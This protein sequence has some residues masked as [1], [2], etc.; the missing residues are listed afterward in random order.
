MSSWTLSWRLLFRQGRSG[1]L[2]LLLAGLVVA[3]AALTAVGLF[4]DRVSRALERQASETLAADL[5]IASR[6]PSAET[7][8][9]QAQ[10][11]G[12]ESV[13]MVTI[14][15]AVFINDQ[16]QL[17]DI[18]A[19]SEGY[20]LRG[21]VGVRQTLM[22]EETRGQM[23]PTRG[24]AWFEPRG[25]RELG[26]EIDDAMDIGQLSL[27]LT[28]ALSYEPDGGGSQFM[29]APRLLMHIDDLKDSGLLG[30]GA[31]TRYRLLIAGEE[32][33]VAAYARWIQNQWAQAETKG[34]QRLITP[35]EGEAQTAEALTQARRFLG[36]AALTTVI[37]AA[38][39]ILL[40]ALRFALAQ[41]DLVALLK[42]FGARST[43]ILGALTWM[44]AWLVA[45]AVVMGGLA[46]FAVQH[47]L[48]EVLSGVGTEGLPGPRLSPW[49]VASSL[50]ALLG[51]G[52]ALPPLWGLKRVAPIRILNRSLDQQ[53]PLSW[54]LWLVL[55]AV[56]LAIPALQLGDTTLAVIVLGGALG[57]AVVLAFFAWLAMHLTRLASRQAKAAWRFGLAGLYRRR[58][59]GIIQITALGLGLMALLLLMVVRSEL[60]T[61]WQAT[62]PEDAPNH[63]VV[64]IQ[65]DQK[66]AVFD[67]LDQAGAQNLQMGPMA[68]VRLI[69][70]NDEPPP[71][72]RFTG[73]VNVSWVSP[74][75]IDRLPPAN[76]ISAGRFFQ[77]DSSAEVSLANRW[78]DR[79]GVGLGDV[80]VF[81]SGAETFS[82]T[83][84]SLR[85]VEW[86]SFNI[87]FFILLTPDAGLSLPHQNI[88]SFYWPKNN[89]GGSLSEINDQYPNVSILDVGGLIERVFEIIERVSQAAEVV[90][91]LTLLAGLIVLL[92]ALEATRDERRHESALIRALGASR[93]MVRR[94]LMIEY[95]IMALIAGALA[96][97]GAA[98]TGQ[99]LASELFGF[100]YT[101]SPW[102]FVGG[103]GAALLLIV[104]AGWLGNK[105]VMSTPPM[106]ILRGN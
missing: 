14:S 56:G 97:G 81:E 68:S 89:G 46:G 86:N 105:T 50:T 44:V 25:F 3:T 7:W 77:P 102:L 98:I 27:N 28:R 40:S 23:S 52:F 11:M 76:Q 90:F 48:T 84:T 51:A 79:V 4:T 62:L 45:L 22:G 65:P 58:G 74:E 15:S 78:A 12:L 1:A 18:K 30:P 19:V 47:I 13:S 82:A 73:Q 80:L 72:D 31:R 16:S 17:I 32:A 67:G 101:P 69:S 9:T 94:G 55:V 63:F 26:L 66:D 60:I 20:P 5:V 10:T 61:Q 91:V 34:D 49:L 21:Q 95:G 42:T 88:A 71:A 93:S 41:R 92:A 99:L 39:A 29:V 83:V 104:G 59:A 70:I 85:E 37:L 6:D 75:T 43:T 57:L 96:T 38:V 35:A 2:L 53:N 87:N 106:R 100:A 33:Q 8:I 64:N 24:E 54:G 103:I 36:V